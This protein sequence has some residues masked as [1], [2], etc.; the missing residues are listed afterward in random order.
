MQALKLIDRIG[1]FNNRV[2]SQ[3]A[4]VGDSCLPCTIGN[5]LSWSKLGRTKCL[6]SKPILW[7]SQLSTEEKAQTRAY[8][9]DPLCTLL[10]AC[11][12]LNND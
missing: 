6:R 3:E 7:Y 8:L 5:V 4:R 1:G 10:L 11:L 2:F 9:A 12:A